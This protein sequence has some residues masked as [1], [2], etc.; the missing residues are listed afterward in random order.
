MTL[1]ASDYLEYYLT[2]LGWIV[3][4]GI[5]N[6]L[7]A[8][9][10]I[11]L[12]FIAIVLQEWLRSR[13]E[14]FDEGNKGALSAVRIENRVWV[15][16]AIIMFA[17]I[18]F[19]PINVSTIQFDRARSEQCQV[20]VPLPNETG[21][22]PAFSSIND[23]TALVPVW[24]FFMHSLSRAL[25]SAA[26]AAIPCGAD[27]RQMRID[28]NASAI[29]NP[30]LSQEIVDFTR[31]CYAP[32]RS[33]LFASRPSLDETETNDVTWIGSGY[34]LSTPGFYDTYHSRTPR[35]AWQYDPTRDA[36]LAE[37]PEG[38]GYPTCTQWWTDETSGL[39]TRLLQQV[40]PDLLLRFRQWAGFLTSAEVDDAVIRA[41]A[42]PR[43][44]L[45]NRGRVYTD[46]GG[47]I[48]MTLPN[49][50]T[51]IASDLGVIIGTLGF[52][53]AMDVVRQ[54]LPMVLSL[55]KMAIVICIPLVL[56]V[57]TFDL[58]TLVTLSS[59]EFAVFF[60]DFWFQLARWVDSTIMNALYGSGAPHSNFNALL[61]L[62]NEFGDMLVNWFV[63]P[64]MFLVLPALWVTALAWTGVRAGNFLHGLSEGTRAAG[65]AGSQGVGAMRLPR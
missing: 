59:V 62:N 19:V 30:V 1:Y 16:I 15:A 40:A 10:L 20:S 27:V 11:A 38:G 22:E 8:S 31:D 32:A 57:G 36:G 12:P 33:R 28:I 5:W 17:G 9:G 34:F 55:L 25:T 47:Q 2:L 43:Q 58:K 54:A 45:V 42:S 63:L 4:N 64:M 50:A 3:N 35:A 65:Q 51:R 44:Q 14:G 24:W 48:N 41:L 61:G 53:P 52:V 49:V 60:T 23:Q 18:P 37:V 21:W 39:R 7:V 13:A 26:V 56:V 29:D 6:V 46:Y